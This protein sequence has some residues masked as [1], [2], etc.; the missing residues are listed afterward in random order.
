MNYYIINH[1]K[2]MEITNFINDYSH[3]PNDKFIQML[4]TTIYNLVSNNSIE[5]NKMIIKEFVGDIYDAIK[6]YRINV[7]ITITKELFYQQLAY[8]SII[9]KFQKEIEKLNKK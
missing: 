2:K 7:N 1:N 8:I 4:Q 9:S 6:I 5:L 3:M